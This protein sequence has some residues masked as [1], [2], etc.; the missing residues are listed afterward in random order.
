GR[1]A[2]GVLRNWF[3]TRSLTPPLRQ[4]PPHLQK[5]LTIGVGRAIV[6]QVARLLP[7]PR[8]GARSLVQVLYHPLHTRPQRLVLL[9]PPLGLGAGG[10][11]LVFQTPLFG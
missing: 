5:G 2:S 4:H 9:L 1:S 11:E 3:H 6:I 8:G 10:G 7:V